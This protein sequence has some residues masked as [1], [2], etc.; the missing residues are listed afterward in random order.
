MLIRQRPICFA[1]GTLDQGGIGRNSLNLAEEL[2]RRGRAVDFF[3]TKAGGAY[4]PQVPAAIRVF[5]GKGSA[6]RS[7]GTLVAYIRRERPAVIIS[8]HPHIHVLV[9][10]A[11]RLSRADVKIVCTV[12]THLSVDRT[13]KGIYK[14]LLIDAARYAYRSADAVVAVSAGVA[15]DLS[16]HFGIARA[17]VQVIYNPALPPRFSDLGTQDVDCGWLKDREHRVV[18]GVGRLTKQKDFPTLIRAF[19]NIRQVVDGCRLVI[20][21]EGEE[22]AA[23]ARLVAEL[24]LVEVVYMPGFVSNPAAYVARASVFAMSSAWEGFGNVLV[25]AMALGTPVVATDC[26]SGP[27]EI[28]DGGRFGRMVPVGD[29]AALAAAVLEELD[30][31]TPPALLRSRAQVFS[32]ESAGD[33]WLALLDGLR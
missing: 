11:V 4:M 5:T 12:R 29:A 25:E 22:R 18:I 23:L 26:P 32:A 33:K 14:N 1:P 21:G 13:S 31:P 16:E 10:A 20:L 19:A 6:R 17:R 28:L 30:R 3:L 2:L 8:A 27:S 7:I 9:A 15:D 24:G